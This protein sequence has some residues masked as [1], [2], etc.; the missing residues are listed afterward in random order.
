MSITV[1]PGLAAA[2]AKKR[3]LAFVAPTTK[4]VTY[5]VTGLVNGVTQTSAII[6]QDIAAGAAGCVTSQTST[7]ITCTTSIPAPVG[8]DTILVKTYDTAGAPAGSTLLGQATSTVTIVANTANTPAPLIV[9]G[10]TA[11]IDL[12]LAQPTIATATAGQSLLVVVPLDSSGNQIIEPG[13]YDQPIT[14]SFGSANAHVTFL[15]GSAQG[16]A[17]TTVTSPANQVYVKYDGLGTAGVVNV[18]A[19]TTESPNGTPVNISASTPFTIGAAP[20]VAAPTLGGAAAQA[21]GFVFTGSGQ[22]GTITYSSPGTLTATVPP[23]DASIATASVSGSTVTITSGAFGTAS[24]AVTQNGSTVTY[25]IS[26]VAPAIS[27]TYTCTNGVTQ[28][29]DAGIIFPTIANDSGLTATGT[30]SGGNGT[31]TPSFASGGSSN[32]GGIASATISG[33]TLTITPLANGTD[34]LL[35]SGGNQTLYLPITVSSGA[36]SETITATSHAYFDGSALT[37]DKSTGQAL[38]TVQNGGTVTASGQ[39]MNALP[40]PVVTLTQQSQSSDYTI[41]AGPNT[42]SCGLTLTPAGGTPFSITV[43]NVAPIAVM[44]PQLSFDALGETASINFT[45]GSGVYTTNG[46]TNTAVVTVGT[47]TTSGSLPYLTGTVPLAV[48]APGSSP[49]PVTGSSAVTLTDSRLGDSVGVSVDQTNAFAK[50]LAPVGFN[51]DGNQS[52]MSNQSVSNYNYTVS[53]ITCPTSCPFNSF[54]ANGN[55]F[56]V[57]YPVAGSGSPGNGLL[58]FSKSG[59]TGYALVPYTVMTFAYNNNALQTGVPGATYDESFGAVGASDTVPVSGLSSSYD[60]TVSSDNSG[61]VTASVIDGSIALTS[62]AAGT[63]N[64]TVT[65]GVTGASAFFSVSVTTT[66]IPISGHG[67]KPR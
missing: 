1:N 20:T 26:V 15:N 57:V 50:T 52:E 6:E 67:R 21:A 60:F 23:A 38:L 49:A 31:Y 19:S 35:V 5:Q 65:D 40:S 51:G 30:L 64:V 3:R 12:F 14:L 66:T 27:A 7:A 29:T 46:G 28:C 41:T 8:T 37:L 39:C 32:S 25:P 42:G 62:V 59:S 48:P 18:I 13:N 47:P 22:T 4:A 16:A 45:G 56:N 34:V 33:N 53:A 2:S 10:V 43:N 58:E 61:V 11:N 36:F 54:P 24:V 55:V 44:S 63:A 17:T 9:N